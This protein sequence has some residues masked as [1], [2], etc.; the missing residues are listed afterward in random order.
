[1]TLS[2]FFVQRSGGVKKEKSILQLFPGDVR[3]YFETVAAR[4]EDLSEI[5]IRAGRPVII[6][7][8]GTEFYL[9]E[10]GTEKLAEGNFF[11]N[12]LCPEISQV[13]N[14]FSYLC[15]YSPYA[16]AEA[17][18]QG[19]LTVSGGHRVGVAGQVFRTGDGIGGIRNIRFL[20]IRI[21]H[22]IKGVAKP[23]VPYL[24]E[25]G[26][27]KIQNCLVIS[28]PG[29]GK[30]TMLRD[31]V[32]L[33]SDGDADR[34]GCQVSIVDERSEIAGCF[35][36]E[37]QNDVG[38]RTDVLDACPKALGMEMMLRAMAPE[39]LAVDEIA[40]KEDV[41][42]L[43]LLLHCGV[44]VLA[45]VHGETMEEVM[46]KPYLRPLFET[47]YFRR[48]IVLEE[49]GKVRLFNEKGEVIG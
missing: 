32:R 16:H 13:D 5:R 3:E 35:Q 8:R 42:T 7:R 28:P 20:N 23:Y 41:E 18:K 40:M 49:K 11:D 36:G 25:K 10:N 31:M 38:V 19:F 45:T 33:I 2:Y 4:Y 39:V 22:E 26:S 34:K 30:T 12:A 1:M 17:L 48:F 27:G 14:M 6:S 47:N 21:S 43:L 24:Y 37:P 29:R 46:G 15:Q 9:A 44:R